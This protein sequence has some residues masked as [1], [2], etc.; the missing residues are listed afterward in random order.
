[1]HLRNDSASRASGGCE[2]DEIGRSRYPRALSGAMPR[3]IIRD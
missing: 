3:N 2:V 1:L